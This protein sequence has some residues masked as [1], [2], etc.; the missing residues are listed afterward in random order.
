MTATGLCMALM[1]TCYGNDGPVWKD[2]IISKALVDYKPFITKILHI[3]GDMG[4]TDMSDA[5]AYQTKLTE[6]PQGVFNGLTEVTGFVST[7]VGCTGLTSIPEGL[8]DN[9]TKATEFGSCFSY[10]TALTEI[11]EGLFDNCTDASSFTNTF[12]NCTSLTSIPAGLF[13]NNRKIEYVYC[14][15]QNCT[16]LTGES[17]YTIINV[18]GNDVKVHLYE[19]K[20]YPDVF[21]ALVQYGNCFENC[22]GLTDYATMTSVWK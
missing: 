9:C 11:P 6:I 15:F 17:P 12:Y 3:G 5:F 1:Q 2:Q 21:A 22:T 20:N 7:F 19:R 13:D 16:A 10:C 4:I 18:D 14:T 8:F